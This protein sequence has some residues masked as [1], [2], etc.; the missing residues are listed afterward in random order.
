MYL[1][2]HVDGVFFVEI[3][4]NIDINDYCNELIFFHLVVID[5][6]TFWFMN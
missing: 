1:R 5:C 6:L 4:Y 3:E 2:R